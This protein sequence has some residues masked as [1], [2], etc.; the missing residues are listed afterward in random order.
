MRDGTEG[1]GGGIY[2]TLPATAQPPGLADGRPTRRRAEVGQK[3]RDD[4]D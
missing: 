3:V 2:D 1:W 4:R